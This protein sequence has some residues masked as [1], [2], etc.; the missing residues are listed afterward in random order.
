MALTMSKWNLITGSLLQSEHLANKLMNFSRTLWG[1]ETLLILPFADIWL[2]FWH[3]FHTR[4]MAVCSQ[5]MCSYFGQEK[6]GWE[7]RSRRW[8]PNK[9]LYEGMWSFLCNVEHLHGLAEWQPA[10]HWSLANRGNL[11]STVTEAQEPPQLNPVLAT[12]LWT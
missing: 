12:S 6:M 4:R 5:S 1:R 11:P 10:Y 3:V 8:V 7:R 9:S 2:L